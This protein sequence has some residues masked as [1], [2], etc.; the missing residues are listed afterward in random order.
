MSTAVLTGDN[1]EE[2]AEL[3]PEQAVA[4]LQRQNAR[5]RRKAEAAMNL[6][7]ENANLKSQ[8][9][10]VANQMVRCPVPAQCLLVDLD[11]CLHLSTNAAD[12]TGICMFY[13]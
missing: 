3:S 8:L 4:K 5:L 11:R 7:Q 10:E 2:L 1:L 6:E 13:I 12:C 9:Q